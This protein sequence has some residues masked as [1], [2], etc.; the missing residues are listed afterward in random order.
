MRAAARSRRITF[1]LPALGLGGAEKQ[2]ALLCAHRPDFMRGVDLEINTFLPAS[3][4]SI[5]QAFEEH[6][7]RV[8]LINRELL[9]FPRFFLQLVQHYRESRPQIVHTLLDSSTGTWGRSA[10]LLTGVPNI[11]HSDL[12]LATSGTR[13]HY[14]IRPF[15][16]RRTTRFLPNAETIAERLRT[17]G[18]RAEQITLMPNA[19]DLDR[20]APATGRS[21]REDLG[22]APDAVVAGFL[23]RFSRV[24]RLDL[25]LEAVTQLPL[26]D[27]PDC[28]L[29]AGDG[30]ETR[31][32]LQR[33][34]ADPWLSAH[35]KLLG[36]IEN[37][38][39]FLATLDYL[40]L[41]SDTEGLPNAVLEAMAMKLPIVSTDV[42]DLPQLVADAGF[43][44]R[45]GDVRSLAAALSRMQS[46]SP[47]Q[48][49][50]LGEKAR[51]KVEQ[52]HELKS[53]A[54]AFWHAHYEV[55][56]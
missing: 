45:A 12:S 43:L 51:V 55:L 19:L 6:D 10:A 4:Q 33:V 27:R 48:R 1:V 13:V 50:R 23:G 39:E 28:L 32:V 42:S 2:L 38:P 49:A 54:Q 44:A 3:S 15:L 46:L 52:R 29:L 17:S 18:V 56:A 5:R 37:I 9:S 7:V 11:F 34:S 31:A 25:L 26:H 24:K 20:F 40:V 41:C 30:P 53:V 36:A 16:D 47:S 22:L 14:L 8:T 21:L 35:V